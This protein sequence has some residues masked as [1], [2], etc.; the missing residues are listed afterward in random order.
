MQTIYTFLNSWQ[1]EDKLVADYVTNV[2]ELS[3][4]MYNQF[5]I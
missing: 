2:D 5:K 3:I 1:K 4:C